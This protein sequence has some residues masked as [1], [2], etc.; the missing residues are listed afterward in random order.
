MV[1][2]SKN[3]ARL[4]ELT[5]YSGAKCYLLIADHHSQMLYVKC[6][7]TKSAPHEFLD[8]WMNKLSPILDTIPDKYVRMD[9][10]SELGLSA[11]VNEVFEKYG[12]HIERAAPHASVQNAPVER[13]HQTI[14]DGIRTMLLEPSCR[15]ASGPSLS[16]TWS[17]S[18]T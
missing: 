2:K 3:K 14:A 8:Q 9:S 10:G 13:A 1:Q 17:V 7:A 12:Y 16:T 6:F 18:I 15:P 11:K 4:E 5:G